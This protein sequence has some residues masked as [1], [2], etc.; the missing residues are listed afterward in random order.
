MILLPNSKSMRNKKIP[1]LLV[2]GLVFGRIFA[3]QVVDNICMQVIGT[4]GLSSE[5]LGKKYDATLGE[6]MT[7][8]LT[9]TDGEFT[10][11]QGFHQPECSESVSTTDW[12]NQV[13]WQISI[14]P[15][16]AIDWLRLTY[17]HPNSTILDARIWSITG[18]LLKDWHSFPS[19]HIL[20][21]SGM[22]TG[23]YLLE[24][25]DPQTH[26]KTAIRFVKSTN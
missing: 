11:T 18:V 4:T 13:N 10:I 21:C 7:A 8:T 17:Q 25:S 24:L 2:F 9:T 20:D 14:F 16:P 5:K 22:T 12:E 15:N 3:Q 26:Q 6:C 1:L 19:N 23:T